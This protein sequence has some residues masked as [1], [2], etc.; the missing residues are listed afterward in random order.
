MYYRTSSDNIN[1]SRYFKLDGK[2]GEESSSNTFYYQIAAI[3]SSRYNQELYLKRIELF[4]EEA[5][6]YD[7]NSDMVTPIKLNL[8]DNR[9]NQEIKIYNNSTDEEL[10]INN[11]NKSE[12][13][14]K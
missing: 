14:Y 9:G 6:V 5:L 13:L 4:I 7:N 3:L 8:F 12:I 1:W 2:V 11:L 10:V